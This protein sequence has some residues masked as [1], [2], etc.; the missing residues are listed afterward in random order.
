M[1]TV[2]LKTGVTFKGERLWL[3]EGWRERVFKVTESSMLPVGCKVTVP[4]SSI[5]YYLKEK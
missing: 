2:V 1:F 4:V 5:L 3:S